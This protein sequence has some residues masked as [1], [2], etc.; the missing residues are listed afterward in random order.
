MYYLE[1]KKIKK[2]L[3]IFFVVLFFG[4]SVSIFAKNNSGSDKN[5]FLDTD[6]D[7]LS[8][9]EEI[10]YGTDPKK[11]DT[12]G[13]GYSDG[14]EIKSGYDPLKPAPNDKI[15][16]DKKD[17]ENK[18]NIDVAPKNNVKD[19]DFKNSD[20]RENGDDKNL[21][22]EL[23]EKLAVI[24]SSNSSDTKK[25]TVD[26]LNAIVDQAMTESEITFDD[27][28]EIDKSEIKIKKQKYSKL[29]KEEREKRKREDNE[30]YLIA[31]SYLVMNNIPYKISKPED[32][33]GFTKDIMKKITE[34][35]TPEGVS[36]AT[37]Y[38]NNMV[39]KAI[40]AF[41]QLKDIEVPEDMLDMHIKGMKILSY[42]IELGKNTKLN[43]ND[44]IKSII[45]LSNV[46]SLL[47][48]TSDFIDEINDKFSEMGLSLG[49]INI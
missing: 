1:T 36:G 24:I 16:S 15:I 9:Q 27:L 17:D 34:M 13:D 39:N 47:V 44:P 37:D 11:S 3:L 28:P 21:T 18:K 7:G 25:I 19:I 33:D 45:A 14:I 6:Q 12:D 22:K 29:S 35:S 23:S 38:F 2:T 41:K 8:D 4:F 49:E 32:I 20:R 30:E 46:Q 31:V 40:I 42:A 48:L 10:V 26:D 43:H 5:I